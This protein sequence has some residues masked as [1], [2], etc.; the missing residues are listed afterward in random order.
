MPISPEFRTYVLEMLEPLVRALGPI[1]IRSMF[2]GGGVY[3]EDTMFG[4]I[5]DEV[6]YFKVDEGNRAEYEATGMGPFL[7]ERAGRVARVAMSYDQVPPDLMEDAHELSA[8]A[9]R[10]WEAARRSGTRNKGRR[11]RR[12]A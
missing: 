9:G 5:A 8:W 10:A 12:S 2:G 4:L 1:R 7:Y 6:L 3:L 11:K